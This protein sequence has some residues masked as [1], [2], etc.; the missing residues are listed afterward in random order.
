MWFAYHSHRQR[1]TVDTVQPHPAWSTYLSRIIP[2]SRC[3]LFL[4]RILLHPCLRTNGLLPTAFTLFFHVD[5]DVDVNVPFPLLATHCH[6]PRRSEWKDTK[7]TLYDCPETLP[8]KGFQISIVYVSDI[9]PRN[10]QGPWGHHL[11]HTSS[12][13]LRSDKMIKVPYDGP[14]SR[15]E[16]RGDSAPDLLWGIA[17]MSGEFDGEAC[18]NFKGEIRGGNLRGRVTH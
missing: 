18:P 10:R 14:P 2:Q 12:I 3:L 4:S 8:K 1:R 16:D 15:T 7:T 6:G 5:V 13:H 9:L 11:F 17:R